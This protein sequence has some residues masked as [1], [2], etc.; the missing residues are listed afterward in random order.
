MFRYMRALSSL[1]V[2][3]GI[4]LATSACGGSHRNTPG[5]TAVAPAPQISERTVSSSGLILGGRARCTATA[6]TPVEAGREIEV[7]F[8]LRNVSGSAVKAPTVEGSFALIVKAADGTT[9]NTTAASSAQG[10]LGGPYRTP[11]TI[12]PRAMTE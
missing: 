4:A 5:T 8:S 12:A 9:Y 2:L 10:S 7:R 1:G 6:T 11:V 3:V